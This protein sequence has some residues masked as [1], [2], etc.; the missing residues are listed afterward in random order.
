VATKSEYGQREIEAAKSVLIELM[1]ILGEYRDQMVLVG[2][3][4]PFFLFGSEHIGS[5]DVDIALDKSEINDE[6]YKTI[7]EHLESRGYRQGEKP[8]IF[9]KEVSVDDGKPIIV[10]A[11]FLAGEYG[12][13]G[14]KHRHQVVQDNLKARKIRGCELA[15]EYHTEITV[16]G[17]M[18]GG[19]VNKVQVN[20]SDVVP[21]IVMKGM[22]LYGRMKEKDAWDIYFCLRNYEGGFEKLAKE[23]DPVI[24]N[25]L[26]QEG[27][28]K[29]RS[30]FA[31]VDGYGPTCVVD[32]EEITDR[33]ER[34]RIKRD[35]FERVK[36]LLDALEISGF[37]E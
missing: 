4:V 8:F 12:G 22:A 1:Q 20:L 33:D 18:P 13:T 37:K 34:E 32:F 36:A 9:L 15:L 30:K 10:Q 3:W 29:I 6:V 2:G 28:E 26:V 25:K 21:F 23:F 27:L 17:K 5:T 35:A 16:E 11:E 24:K 31:S 7:R 14:K 19:A